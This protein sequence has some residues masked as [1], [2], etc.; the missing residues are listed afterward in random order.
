MCLQNTIGISAKLRSLGP[1]QRFENTFWILQRR[2]QTNQTHISPTLHVGPNNQ[3]KFG[4]KCKNVISD[5]KMAVIAQ[6]QG[7][8]RSI[9]QTRCP[10]PTAMSVPCFVGITKKDLEKS[11]IMWPPFPEVKVV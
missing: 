2:L 4:E 8:L 1:E 3:N 6:G 5:L 11:E 10:L 7:P 9:S